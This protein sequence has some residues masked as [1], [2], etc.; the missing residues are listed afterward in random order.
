MRS[1]VIV[2]VVAGLLLL[3]VSTVLAQQ[4]TMVTLLHFSDYHSHAVP[5]YSEGEADAAGLARAIAYLNIFADDPNA[6]IFNGGDTINKGSPAWS[7]KFQ[8]LEWPLF[9][10]LVDAMAFGNHDADYGAEI[11]VQCQAQVAYPILSSNVLDSNGQPL[12]QYESQTYQIFEVDGIKIGVFAL[13]GSD[14]ERLVKLETMPAPEVSFADRVETAQEVVQTLREE[15]QVAAVVLIGHALHEDDVSLA[16]SVPGIDLIFGTHSHRKEGLTQIPNTDT[17][18]ISPYQYLSYVSKVELK[19]SDGTLNEIHGEL[20]KMSS[21]LPEDSEIAQK[22][23]QLQA[24]LEADPDYAHLFQ[25]IGE[26]AIELSTD[27]QFTGEALLGNWVM[28]VVREAAGAHLSIFVASGFRQ[29]IPPGIIIEQDLL[30]AMPYKNTVFV[31]DMSGVQVKELL[32]YSVSRSG[33]D[34]FS[35]VS[36]VRFNVVDGK[37]VDIQILNDPVDPSGGFSSLNADKIYQVATSNF[38]G[39]YAGGYKDIF[40]QA[41]YVETGLDV[42]DVVRQ[43][44]QA[45]SPVSADLDGRIHSDSP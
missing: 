12:F 22:V 3:V 9:N 32:D 38:Q 35:Q 45:N 27:G 11:F 19:F 33:S 6:L 13:A 44:I 34:F 10:G 36:G 41:S 4:D 15:E 37:A 24:E 8:C 30:T 17:F 25:P 21:D 29:P 2:L 16:Q 31:Y 43:Y 18:I 20:V 26:T 14:F 42:W 28:D 1:R 5:F 40:A 23:A 7:D 39:L